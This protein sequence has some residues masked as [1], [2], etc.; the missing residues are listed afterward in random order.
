MHMTEE[1]EDSE[2]QSARERYYLT[3]DDTSPLWYVMLDGNPRLLDFQLRR[4]NALRRQDG[5]TGTGLLE[6]FIP[7]CFL[8]HTSEKENEKQR[9][10]AAWANSLRTDL[11]DFAFIHATPR[12]MARLLDRQWRRTMRSRLHHYRNIH[13]EAITLTGEEMDRLIRVFS[14]NRIR[15]SIGL[16]VMNIGPDVEV[17]IIRDGTFKGQTARIISVR[18]TADGIFLNIG[19][20]MFQGMKELRLRDM[21]LDDIQRKGGS[22]ELIGDRFIRDTESALTDIISRRVNHKET[23]ASERDDVATL[24]HLFLFSYVTVGDPEA[25]ARFL[26]L[27]LICSTLRFDRDS[28]QV[29]LRRV[30]ELLSGSDSLKPDIRAYLNLSLYIATRDA[31]YRTAAK[32]LVREHPD[33]ASEGLRRLLAL[34]SRMHSRRA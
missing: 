31:N 19:I 15:F 18:H 32:Q 10:E 14:E 1:Y 22:D 8:P 30:E 17:Q 2:R 12:G 11:H 16:P 24:N 3:L 13:G 4:E 28:T 7:F 26:S 23:E 21:T 29:L 9:R 6:Y 5:V 34:A 20:K 27:M 25:C 33:G